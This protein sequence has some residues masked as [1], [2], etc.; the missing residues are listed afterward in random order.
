MKNIQTPL[1]RLF[2]FSS[3][4]LATS[5]L[6]YGQNYTITTTGGDV[7]ITDNSGGNETL[8]MSQS[9][10]N[11]Q[12]NVSGG[13]T[14]SLNGGSPTAF[15]FTIALTGINSITIN[16]GGGNDVININAFTSPLPALTING[17]TGN[18][19]VNFNGDVTFQTDANLDVDLQNDD[20]SPGTD[21]VVFAT[22]A[23]VLLQ[24]SGYVVIKVSQ[25]VQFNNSSTLRTQNGNITIE[26][27]QQATPTT[28]VSFSGVNIGPNC[29]VESTGTG[30]VII[31]GRGGDAAGGS[32]YGVNLEGPTTV[33]RGGAALGG[34][35]VQGQG[36]NSGGGSNHGVRVNGNGSL[37]TSYGGDVTVEGTGGGTGGSNNNRGVLVDNSGQITAGG[38]G[39]VTVTGQGG[40]NAGGQSNHGVGLF[41]SGII[42]SSGGNVTVQGTGG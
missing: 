18:D 1:Q 23:D 16:T 7:V 13:A 15:P 8:T 19:V 22:N 4:F 42:T 2:L 3:F 17:G 34:A 25:N 20:P 24:G 40:T 27:N 37:I 29:V 26:A 21:R 30:L 10:A 35:I 38:S 36:G 33:I 6:C 39:T 28:G 9:G 41:S 14:Y 31:K 5:L 11:L 12:I 32:Q